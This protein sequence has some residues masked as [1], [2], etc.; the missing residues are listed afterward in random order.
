MRGLIVL[1]AM[2]AVGLG[3]ALGAVLRF[4]PGRVPPP[5]T[6][7]APRELAGT[8]RAALGELRELPPLDA[9]SETT[10]RPLFA[11]SRRP[12]QAPAEAPAVVLEQPVEPAAA[13]APLSLAAIVVSDGQ[14]TAYVRGEAEGG[15]VRLHAGERHQGWLVESIRD[16]RIVVSSGGTRQEVML[17]SFDAPPSPAAAAAARSTPRRAPRRPSPGIN[18]N[19]GQSLEQS[20][21]EILKGLVTG[22]PQPGVAGAQPEVRQPVRR[23]RRLDPG[24]STGRSVVRPSVRPSEQQ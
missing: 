11:S 20:A 16:D 9:L 18:P 19:P 22:Q 5:T 3:A 24:S 15:L 21:A 8:A 14:P 1:L 17:R 12:P 23:N 6:T 10:S 4:Q 7:E 13:P 2:M